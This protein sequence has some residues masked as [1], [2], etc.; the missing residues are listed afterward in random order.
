M[1]CMRR[2][3]PEVLSE[4]LREAWVKSD[5]II[6][7]SALE[8]YIRSRAAEVMEYLKKIFRNF[9]VNY[10]HGAANRFRQLYGIQPILNFQVRSE[11]D[12]DALV[13]ECALPPDTYEKVRRAVERRI[14]AERGLGR[15]RIK[16]LYELI[17]GELESA[18]GELGAVLPAGPQ[19]APEG[20]H[21]AGGGGEEVRDQEG[22]HSDEGA[23]EG[24]VRGV[25]VGGEEE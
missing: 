14:R 18:T 6:A 4:A 13:V 7:E 8:S 20:L 2:L 11:G 3:Q 21:K 25:P 15:I 9:I 1:N 10:A 22:G 17:R 16:A 5:E 23:D 12:Y 24:A 19:P